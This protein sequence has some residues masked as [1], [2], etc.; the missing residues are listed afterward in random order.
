MTN[1]STQNVA[2]EWRLAAELA[3]E[4][5]PQSELDSLIAEISA[6][7]AAE[8][9]ASEHEVATFAARC[10]QAG[11]RDD[12]RT[13]RSEWSVVVRLQAR[14]RWLSEIADMA[15]ESRYAV[16]ATRTGVWRDD[17][18]EGGVW[19]GAAL[20]DDGLWESYVGLVRVAASH[21]RSGPDRDRACR[22]ARALRTRRP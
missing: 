20:E 19:V 16:S 8:R 11:T 10:A 13:T 4:A 17:G 2:S 1:L 7:H 3:A 21:L 12:A 22:E 9:A 6:T 14:R 18:S 5:V 15:R